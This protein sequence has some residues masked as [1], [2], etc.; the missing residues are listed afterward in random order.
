MCLH[1]IHDV[2]RNTMFKPYVSMKETFDDNHC[3][4]HNHLRVESE[5][6]DPMIST[7]PIVP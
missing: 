6:R 4:F 7:S 5:L 3:S 1:V 2:N